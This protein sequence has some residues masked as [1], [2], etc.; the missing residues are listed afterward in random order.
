MSDNITANDVQAK[1][2]LAI[3]GKKGKGF[4]YLD[5]KW[6]KKKSQTGL[7]NIA[8]FLTAINAGTEVAI[9]LLQRLSTECMAVTVY[10][11]NV[12]KEQAKSTLQDYYNAF[13]FKG[14]TEEIKAKKDNP[15]NGV[16]KGD[17]IGI[18][19]YRTPRV[20]VPSH[21]ST[22]AILAKL[23]VDTPAK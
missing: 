10:Y 20:E 11:D 19:G 15:A 5:S 13:R 16:V 7:K 14:R 22:C 1:I 23:T 2:M 18:S 9:N 21:Q 8:E 6:F 4:Q 3:A 12:T 17:I